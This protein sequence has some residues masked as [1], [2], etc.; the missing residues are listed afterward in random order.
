MYSWAAD[1]ESLRKS[2][3]PS[4]ELRVAVTFRRPDAKPGPIKFD[5]P[6]SLESVKDFVPDPLEMDRAICELG[7]RG[8][9]LTGRGRLTVSMRCK[10]DKFEKVFGT[11]LKKK[12]LDPEQNYATHSFYF[13]PRGARWKPDKVIE[14]LIDDACIQW[15]QIWP[16][17]GNKSPSSRKKVA[18]KGSAV[19]G[20][21]LP[22]TNPPNVNYFHL[23]PNDIPSLLNATKVHRAGNTGEGI[24]VVMIDTGFA[25][26]SHPFFAANGFNSTVDLAFGAVND[27]TDRIGHG[28]GESAN[29]FSVA[30]GATFI[31]VKVDSEDGKRER[32]CTLEA[33]QT[34]LQHRPHIIC[35]SKGADLRNKKTKKQFSKLP[36]N[37]V[38]LQVEIQAAVASGI[39]V[40]FSAGNGEFSFPAMMPD[41]ISVGGVFVDKRGNM[42]ASDMASA[43]DTKIYS[44]RHVPDFCGLV[45]MNEYGDRYIMLPVPPHCTMDQLCSIGPEGTGTS[46]GWAAFSGTSAAAPQIAGVCALLKA[47]NPNLTPSDI[48][49]VLRRTARSVLVGCSN[50]ACSDDGKTPLKAGPGDDGATG[51]GLAD[52]FSAWQQV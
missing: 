11:K 38:P 31:G 40:V 32:A 44:G 33:F 8:F 18:S 52:A 17:A 13:P 14:N 48:K 7:K 37:L 34:A 27:E 36:R 1:L 4:E 26:R 45:G 19:R 50:P 28:T 5:A 30:P 51:A 15:P 3:G 42:R 41:V 22:S 24:R 43:F 6:L 2:A 47:K 12:D 16:M 29:F 35:I 10:K 21:A 20:Q 9:E 23:V 46:D 25:H 49:A 39:I